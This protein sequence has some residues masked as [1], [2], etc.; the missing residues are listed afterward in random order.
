VTTKAQRAVL[1]VLD[2]A[3]TFL[4]AQGIHARL[5]GQGSGVGLTSVY[6]ALQ[7]LADDGSVDVLRTAGGE[8]TFRRCDT[9]SHH[10]HLVCKRCGA[11]VEVEA[12]GLER[13]LAAIAR[14]H[15]YDVEGHTL[16][17]VGVCARCTSGAA[18]EP[19]A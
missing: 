4:S 6:R 3:D 15:G 11:T 16:E 1:G 19:S 17:V 7:A 2:D 13:W 5:R 9:R 14:T 12:P 18:T 10:H 8:S